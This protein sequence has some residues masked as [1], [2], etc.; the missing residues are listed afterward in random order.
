MKTEFDPS[1]NA[2]NIAERGLIFEQVAEFDFK[3]A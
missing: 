1:K 2:K 3:T